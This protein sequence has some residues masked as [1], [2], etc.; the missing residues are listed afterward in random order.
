MTNSPP[1]P[2]PLLARVAA[3]A[4][5][6]ALLAFAPPRATA[7]DLPLID[8]AAPGAESRVKVGHGCDSQV[9]TKIAEAAG[10]KALAISIQPGPAGY[11]GVEIKP[12]HGSWDL[13]A[14]DHVEVRVVNTGEN[15][16]LIALRVDNAGN[17]KSN[18]WNCEQATLQPGAE[19]TL[20]TWFGFSYGRQ[21]GFA[22][23]PAAVVN[24]VLFTKKAEVPVS[25][26]VESLVAS[27]S[28]KAN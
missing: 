19:A 22:L 26:R 16:A 27:G 25:F 3:A 2:I 14:Y 5:A 1:R 21:P 10:K 13:S 28:G 7:A 24:V 15:P 11:P 23:N 4:L 9:S 8:F 6:A 17:W 20:S 12:E 18:P